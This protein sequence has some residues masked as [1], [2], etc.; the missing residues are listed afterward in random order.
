MLGQC[1]AADRQIAKVVECLPALAAGKTL[2]NTSRCPE[3]SALVPGILQLHA[4][5]V[6]AQWGYKA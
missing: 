2:F 5:A 4:D 1:V 3:L 6:S